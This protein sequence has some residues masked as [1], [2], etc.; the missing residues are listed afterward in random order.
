MCPRPA[1]L[2]EDG[3]NQAVTETVALEAMHLAG[4]AVPQVVIYQVIL[5]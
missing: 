3:G 4:Q 5:M 1:A 2:G